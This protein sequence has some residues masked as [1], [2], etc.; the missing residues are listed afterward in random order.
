MGLLV[1][2][3]V[4]LTSVLMVLAAEPSGNDWFQIKANPF[5]G[6]DDT[7]DGGTGDP[8]D[9]NY[10]YVDQVFT[11]QIAINSTGTTASNI[12]VDFDPTLIQ[13]NS[14]A[15]GDYYSNWQNQNVNNGRI[16]STGYNFPLGQSSGE[17]DF[18]SI[19]VQLK[20]PSAVNYGT[21]APV[22]LDINTGTIGDTKESNISYNGQDLLDNAEDFQFHIWADTKK[23]Y[24]KSSLPADGAVGVLVDSIYVFEL[25]DSLNGEGDD[26]GVGTGVD[27]NSSNADITFDTG[28]GPV[29]LKAFV[30]YTCS[31]IWGSNL[32]EVSVDS[33]SDTEY[34]GDTRKWDYNTI[35][36]VNIS[37]Y[38][39]LASSNQNQLG[40][41]NGPNIMDTKTYT[42]TTEPDM[43]DPLVQK[44]FPISGSNDHPLDTAISF[45]IIDKKDYLGGISGSGVD[46]S[47]CNI[48][49]SS[50][51]LGSTTYTA[52]DAEVSSSEIDYGYSVVVDPISDFA[53]NETVSVRIS[54]CEDYAL[55]SIAEQT[56]TFNTVI[57]DVDNDGVLDS[58]D[59]CVDI[60]NANQLDT[61]SDGIGD[62]CDTDIDGDGVVNDVDNCPLIQNSQQKDID[63]DGIGDVCD[64][65]HDNDGILNDVDNCVLDANSDQKDTDLDGAGDACDV[66]IDNDGIINEEDNCPLNVNPDQ[67]DFDQDGLGDVCDDDIDSDE[68]LNPD[69]NCPYFN[70][71]DQKD[72]DADTIGDPCDDD[73]DND[74]IPNS[75]DNCPFILNPGQEDSDED[76]FGDVCDIDVGELSFNIKA[77][78]EKRVVINGI[79]S[80]NLNAGLTYYNLSSK[81]IFLEDDVVL[82][83]DGT[84]SYANDELSIGDYDVS[85]KG[86]SHLRRIIRNIV[87]GSDIF[88]VNLDFTF[89]DSFELIAGD[90][91]DDNFI[92]SYDL[93]TMLK[94]YGTISGGISDLN[95][96]GYV[97]APDIALLILNY[98]KKGDEF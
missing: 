12:W 32:C 33:P 38:Q 95:K 98:F 18:G 46:I 22:V 6:A 75:E 56:I 89:G 15:T 34:V 10:Y 53:S 40:D 48:V 88:T 45:E 62:V 35:Y 9:L 73:I 94:T 86:E 63:S 41:T 49:V 3:I 4:S 80:L 50:P 61:D 16:K 74:S 44:L 65:D 42:F 13:I 51:S 52:S 21:G 23:P 79:S 97:N 83:T 29:S 17:G 67:E 14:V 27:I 11:G 81:D 26:S 96:D 64:N 70:N 87:I 77:K 57:L 43:V 25:F 85:L 69:D 7:G 58:A 71:P 82:G 24:A 30:L 68:I 59:N 92:N 37:G 28:A 90:L 91:H 72:T 84:L 66:D 8:T 19:E 60:P 31:G 2:A 78:P 20:Y 54:D 76:G 1:V 5:T 93:S 47:T 55:N 39:D 36:T